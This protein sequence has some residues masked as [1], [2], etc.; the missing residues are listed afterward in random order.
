MLVAAGDHIARLAQPDS[1]ATPRANAN[2][3]VLEFMEVISASSRRARTQL[4]NASTPKVHLCQE[5]PCRGEDVAPHAAAYAPIGRDHP[6]D[7]RAE[8]VSHRDAVAGWAQASAKAWLA[9]SGIRTSWA[10]IEPGGGSVGSD[11]A[12]AAALAVTRPTRVHLESGRGRCRSPNPSRKTRGARL[13]WRYAQS[14][15]GIPPASRLSVAGAGFFQSQPDS[16]RMLARRASDS[17]VPNPV[18]PGCVI[19]TLRVT[20]WSESGLNAPTKRAINLS[21]FMP[22]A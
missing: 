12:S 18:P 21:L 22:K 2:K 3:V 13:T 7:L 1:G 19:V 16:L 17:R 6:L 8:R 5:H 14:R 11:D 10:D 9:F 4:E 15:Q 20:S